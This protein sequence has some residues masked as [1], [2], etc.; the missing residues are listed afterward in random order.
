MGVKT[1]VHEKVVET[2]KLIIK[3]DGNQI[4]LEGGGIQILDSSGNPRVELT[5]GESPAIYLRSENGEITGAMLT[6]QDGGTAVGLADAN[7]NVAALL[8]GGETPSISLFQ[9]ATQP[10]IAL[11]IA[12]DTP[13]F[14]L[15]SKKSHDSVLVHG[16]E[17]TSLLFVDAAGQV[18]VFLSKHGV[19]QGKQNSEESAK[20]DKNE[21][22]MFTWEEVTGKLGDLKINSSH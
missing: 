11:G 8:R 20:E 12:K 5:G 16:G 3:G 14:L 13:H 4:V 21:G 19:F 2:E 22:K 6:M 18:P 10:N 9:D 1:G 17:T 7:G 15:T